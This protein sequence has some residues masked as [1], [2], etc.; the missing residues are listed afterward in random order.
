MKLSNKIGAFPVIL[1]A[2]S[3]SGCGVARDVQQIRGLS[4]YQEARGKC[5]EQAMTP[6][7]RQKAKELGAMNSSVIS[8][9]RSLEAVKCWNRAYETHYAAH[10]PY[11]DLSHLENT[12]RLAIAEKLASGKINST[13]AE[14]EFAKIQSYV[15]ERKKQRSDRSD[16]IDAQRDAANKTY[17][18]TTYSTGTRCY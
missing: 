8:P 13:E 14:F 17:T 5:V 10:D 11:R 6:A 12:A 18:C 16:L 1:V 7:E 4:S 9:Q 15:S 3:L 2:F